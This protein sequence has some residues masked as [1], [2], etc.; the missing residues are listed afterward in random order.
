MIEGDFGHFT[1]I[2]VDVDLAT[3]LSS[4]LGFEKGGKQIWIEVECENL[5]KFCEIFSMIDDSW[6]DC[7]HDKKKD[8]DPNIVKKLEGTNPTYKLDEKSTSDKQVFK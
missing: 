7:R 8:R 1:W 2:F 4:T 3:S 5:P 6:R